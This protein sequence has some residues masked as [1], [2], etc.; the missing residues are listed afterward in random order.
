MSKRMAKKE[1]EQ[2]ISLALR[3]QSSPLLF[4]SPERQR[5][6][7]GSGLLAVALAMITVVALSLGVTASGGG[8]SRSAGGLRE[9]PLQQAGEAPPACAPTGTSFR[10]QWSTDRSSSSPY[11]T[12]GRVYL[13]NISSEDC[14]LEDA[15]PL[16]LFRYADG[17]RVKAKSGRL[18]VAKSAQVLR[19]GET[20]QSSISWDN[21]CEAVAPHEVVLLLDGEEVK[22]RSDVEPPSPSCNDARESAS[23]ISSR[24]G[25]VTS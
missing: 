20:T 2:H 22:S 14:T 11:S 5:M 7:P 21:Y 23:I 6:R 15:A 16:L 4:V 12:Q 25:R 8:Q 9:G 24:W 3:G 18:Y 19:A 10:V 13:S 1:L 17:K